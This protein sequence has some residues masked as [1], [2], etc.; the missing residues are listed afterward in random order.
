[1][2]KHE[3][4]SYDFDVR[5]KEDEEHGTYLEGQPIVYDSRTD[6][7]L[8][9]EIIEVGALKNT[10]LKDVRFLVNHDFNMIPLAR[11]RNNTKNST[12]QMTVNDEG[13][14]IRVNLDVEGNA[15]AKELYSAVK[16]GDISGMSFAFYIDKEEWEDL[17]TEHPTRRIKS[18][19]EIF[20]VS[21]VTFPAY[22]DTNI[23]ARQNKMVLESAK[24]VLES[25]R[26]SMDIDN[27]DS[28][29]LEK[30]KIKIKLN[31]KEN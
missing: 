25:A 23:S 6:L 8:Y 20:E 7:G 18:I 5:A 27:A 10:N 24:D 21:A 26:R 28:L 15:K 2:K 9:D 19:S 30:E 22:E 16:R 31:L 4:R 17:K 29:E 12:M 13:M 14:S 1:M 3:I 11:S